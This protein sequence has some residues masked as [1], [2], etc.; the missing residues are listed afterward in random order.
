MEQESKYPP[1]YWEEYGSRIIS[2]LGLKKT[3]QGEYHGACPNCGGKDRFWIN[4]KDGL[5]KVHC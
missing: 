1:A 4:Q 2:E 5:V 3:A